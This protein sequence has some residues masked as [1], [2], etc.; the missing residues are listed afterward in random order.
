MASYTNHP[1]NLD[2]ELIGTGWLINNGPPIIQDLSCF[3]IVLGKSD[4]NMPY[5]LGL[6]DS[7]AILYIAVT[8]LVQ[9]LYQK[10]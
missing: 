2:L 7:F 4:E 8:Y 5:W 1:L 6:G 3:L 9:E 10:T